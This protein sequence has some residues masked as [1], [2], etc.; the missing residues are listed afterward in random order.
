MKLV[1]VLWLD[2]LH[3]EEVIT[4]I[5]AKKMEPQTQLT[6][7]LLIK[8]TDKTLIIA[9]TKD[10]QDGN[11]RDIVAIPMVNVIKIEDRGEIDGQVKEEQ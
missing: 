4:L 9:S 2:A 1:L 11:F 7:G 8:E 5:E 10:L 6:V 3:C